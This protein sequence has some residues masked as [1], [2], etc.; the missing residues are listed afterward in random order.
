MQ[1]AAPT[2]D[3]FLESLP[4]ERKTDLT[5]IRA[6]ILELSPELQESM[7][8]KMPTYSDETGKAIFAFNAQKQYLALYVRHIPDDL[9]AALAGCNLGKGCIRFTRLDDGRLKVFRQVLIETR[10]PTA[11]S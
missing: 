9:K 10:H 6:L 7:L 11:E 4:P 8:Y 1:S 2:V 3:A 5:R